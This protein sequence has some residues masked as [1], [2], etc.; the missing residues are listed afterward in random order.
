ML[1]A[2]IQKNL[3][4][5]DNVFQDMKNMSVDAL[6]QS[7]HFLPIHYTFRNSFPYI[8]NMILYCNQ[9]LDGQIDVPDCK[10]TD[11]FSL[12][13]NYRQKID[14]IHR[15]ILQQQMSE[16]IRT[17]FYNDEAI[18]SMGA[19]LYKINRLPSQ[20]GYTYGYVRI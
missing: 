20:Q 16:E 2:V 5:W 19:L 9:Y 1:N 17:D 14:E 18:E 13:E 7:R 3:L 8:D 11:L 6:N 4:L 10:D 12:A 15:V